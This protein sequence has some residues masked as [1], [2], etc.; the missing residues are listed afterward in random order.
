MADNVKFS[1]FLAES[2]HVI[3]KYA[4]NTEQRNLA[5]NG[6][7]ENAGEYILEHSSGISETGLSGVV[8]FVHTLFE[9]AAAVTGSVTLGEEDNAKLKR[10]HDHAM[11]GLAMIGGEE[12]EFDFGSDDD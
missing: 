2:R 9:V 7:A 10:L 5:T 8:Q 12:L 11:Q 6:M 1:G 4:N 3:K